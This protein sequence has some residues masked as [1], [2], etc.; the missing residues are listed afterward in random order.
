MWP[1]D[2]RLLRE[3]PEVFKE[4]FRKRFL[5]ESLVDK[6]LELD[7]RWREK[8]KEVESLR[9][10]INKLS[11][12]YAYLK[13]NQGKIDEDELKKQKLYEIYKEIEEKI[14]EKGIDFIREYVKKIE[15]E[16]KEKEKEAERLKKELITLLWRFPNFL[17][18]DVPTGPDDTYNVP[19][20]F[21]GIPKVH[22]KYLDQF[23][24]Q[25]EKWGWKVIEI[26]KLDEKYIK[27]R[28]LYKEILEYDIWDFDLN[29]AID[30]EKLNKDK[31]AVYKEIYWEP[32]HHYDLV[33][34][35]K[36]A[37]TDKA[38][39]VAGSRF[40]YE[41]GKLVLLDLALALFAIN[42][43]MKKGYK[44]VI[45]PYMLRLEI[46]NSVLDY[47]TFKDMIYKIEGEDLVLIGTAEHPLTA[48]YANEIFE[49]DDLPIKLVG[50]SPC[51]R[52]E[53]GAANKDLKGIFRVHQF[54]KVEQYI[55]CKPE[56]SR[57]YHEEL[58]RNAE[59]IHQKLGL[60]YRIV[61]IASGDL[62][63]PAYKKY[64][65]E[66]WFPA[67]GKYRELVSGSNVTD[68]QARRLNIRFR[69]KDGKIEY[70]HTLNCTGLAHQRVLTAIL[71][72]HYDPEGKIRIPRE[73]AK[74]TGIEII[75][76]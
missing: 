57:K 26:R 24:E 42:H 55:F 34:E 51:F 45:P 20:R 7:K 25:T 53:A 58:I 12:L 13:R 21:W 43:L 15:G 23:K 5:D 41:F 40:Y 30:F 1:I 50:W 59:E 74:L 10:K 70:V 69:R 52:K 60:P 16:L 72:N 48:L 54:H 68:W 14:K 6:A 3:R 39:E 61:N 38:G 64:D 4:V 36:L 35:F 56:E 37:D 76:K 47:E 44:P 65:L 28:L 32:K 31:I 46:I 11:R 17:D 2:I 19:I 62:G 27:D 9:S 73:L 66:A 22:K 71:E 63:L 33:K 29:E 49:E 75:E 18:K 67:Q 8:Q